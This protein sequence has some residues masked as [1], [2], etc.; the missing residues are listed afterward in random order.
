MFWRHD[1]LLL[2]ITKQRSSDS[3]FEIDYKIL[4]WQQISVVAKK[5][6]TRHVCI[7]PIS[8]NKNYQQGDNSGY[9]QWVFKRTV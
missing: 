8:K 2:T 6:P 1:Q 5:Q 7:E 4:T 3:R 9:K